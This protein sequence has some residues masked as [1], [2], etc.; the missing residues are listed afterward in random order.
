MK[1]VLG[2]Q[3]GNEGGAGED[4]TLRPMVLAAPRCVMELKFVA[5]GRRGYS[6]TSPFTK[7]CLL[8]IRNLF[9]FQAPGYCCSVGTDLGCKP[10]VSI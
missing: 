10:H 5:L 7:W 1:T 6:S 4:M 2:G 9:L 3:G 8:D